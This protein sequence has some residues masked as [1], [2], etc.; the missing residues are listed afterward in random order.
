MLCLQHFYNKAYNFPDEA[1]LIL[2]SSLSSWL[3][4]DC[5]IWS[6]TQTGNF[7]THSAYKLLAGGTSANNTSSSNLNSQKSFWSGIWKLRI[8]NKVRHF[9]WRACK[10]ALPT[11]DNLFRRHIAP[12]VLCNNC[13]TELKDPLH[14]VWGCKEVD[15]VR[16]NL[17][18]INQTV[19]SPPTDFFD[20]ISRSL[21]FHDDH[22]KKIFVLAAWLLW[23]CRNA[24][25]LGLPSQPHSMITSLVGGMLQDFLNAQEPDLDLTQSPS[26]QHWC[27]LKS[28]NSVGLG[29][30]VRDND[31][32]WEWQNLTQL[33]NMT[34]LNSKLTSYWLRLNRFVLYSD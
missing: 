30:F 19:T 31:G 24:I 4:Q 3:P 8:P 2:S 21:Q 16:S 12:V 15:I 22:R 25:R 11:V 1:Q 29:V 10:N 13:N 32:E 34:R 26:L 18:R 28:N 9:A 17:S 23:N 5:L 20:L 7:S 27:P 33:A 14:V 6:Q